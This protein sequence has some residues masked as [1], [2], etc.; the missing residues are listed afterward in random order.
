[1]NRFKLLIIALMSLCSCFLLSIQ[2][3]AQPATAPVEVHIDPS[4]DV[5]E[6]EGWGSSLAWWG[7]AVGGT[8][9]A[10]FY[11]DL[12]YTTKLTDGYPGL[13]LNI[14]RY[15][16]GG[17]GIGQPEENK[18]PKLQW[19]MDIHGYWTNPEET[20]P[21]KWDWSVDANQRAMMTKARDR[22]ANLFE[23]FSDSP[24]W[25]MNSNR[26]TAGSG[27]GGDCL[28][29]ANA[30][31]F[32]TYLAN[33]A[34]HAADDWGIKFGSVEPFNE[35]S[36]MWWKYP[37]RQEGCHFDISTQETVMRDLREAL[38]RIGLKDVVVA[39]ADENDIDFG[40][41]TWNAYDE[42]HACKR[43][44]GQCPWLPPW[45]RSVPR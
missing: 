34:R 18:G 24:M 27:S 41:K 2:A 1:V 26:S 21:S 5:G 7:R 10:D 15:N 36:A 4:H 32:A 43:R 44:Q 42:P 6:W 23:M 3:N 8:G 25:W 39:G 30:A 20:D 45:H 9:N 11:A 37:G 38:D 13:G 16:V 14:V 17:G 28:Q 12:M 33:V 19:Q 22:G 31:K 35:P 29:P 40:L